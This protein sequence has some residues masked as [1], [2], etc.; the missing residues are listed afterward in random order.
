MLQKSN[1]DKILEQFFLFPTKR[2]HIREIARATNIAHTSINRYISELLR[3]ELIIKDKELYTAYKAN[4]KSDNFKLLK[5]LY[6]NKTLVESGFVEHIYEKTH[7]EFIILFGSC[8][9]GEDIESSDI[10]IY[11]E[12][13]QKEINLNKY[14]LAF[15][16]KINLYFRKFNKV[17]DELKNNLLNGIILHGF[18]KAY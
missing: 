1:R 7:A 2:W 18:V 16:R 11:L 6:W 8:S 12:S 10:D 5:K 17:Q 13:S 14:E 9:K 15:S 3:E 4:R